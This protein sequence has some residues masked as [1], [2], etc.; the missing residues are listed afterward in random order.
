[1][2]EKPDMRV[3]VV[4]PCGPGRAENVKLALGS[5]SELKG[6]G[7]L[8]GVVVVA[9][10]P[11][12][13]GQ[14][15]E[16]LDPWLGSSGFVGRLARVNAPKFEPGGVQPRNLG[17]QAVNRLSWHVTHVWFVDSDVLVDSGALLAYRDAYLAA[18]EDRVMIG[19]YEW[20]PEGART[21]MRTL[22]NDTRWPAF[23][24]HDPGDVL[25]GDLATALACYG[26]NLVWP[27]G[28][29][30]RVGGFWSEIARGEDGELGLR[31]AAMGVPMSWVKDA[32]GWHVYH[33]VDLQKVF[34]VNIQDIPKI[35]E[36]HPWVKDSGLVV[37]EEDGKRF[38]VSCPCG[39]HGNTAHIWQ[40]QEVDCPQSVR[41]KVGST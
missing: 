1:L 11:E 41:I 10:G 31:A 24:S 37:V 17:V 36:R 20:M 25:V 34:E 33:P 18:E 26:G 2:R 16:T 3:A 23:N 30:Q 38:N 32:R 13:A 29:F 21:P 40:H 28:E 35:A 22:R 15:D 9:D 27:I 6:Q 39:W 12:A 19:P 8:A 5:L 14:L 7:N 4:I